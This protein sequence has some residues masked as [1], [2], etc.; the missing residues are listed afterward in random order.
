MTLNG[1]LTLSVSFA[2]ET[3]FIPCERVLSE[4]ALWPFRLVHV[5]TLNPGQVVS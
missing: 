2:N 5:P 3:V 4:H 1:V